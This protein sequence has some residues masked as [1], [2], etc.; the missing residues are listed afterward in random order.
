[1]P[2]NARCQLR[3]L[4]ALHAIHDD[5]I[6]FSSDAAGQGDEWH[7]HA[8]TISAALIAYFSC[9]AHCRRIYFARPIFAFFFAAGDAEASRRLR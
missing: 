3:R 2:I 1:M 6:P 5:D 7:R 8:T 4:P 9:R